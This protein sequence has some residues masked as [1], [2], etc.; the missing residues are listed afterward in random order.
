MRNGLFVILGLCALAVSV[1][2]ATPSPSAKNLMWR[3]TN[4]ERYAG[5]Y[6]PDV[7]SHSLTATQIDSIWGITSDSSAWVSRSNAFLER[8]TF[9]APIVCA[10]TVKGANIVGT[11]TLNI[12]GASTL[13]GAVGITGAVT[14][15]GATGITGATT[16]TGATG[17][18][19]RTTVTG[20]IAGSDSVNGVTGNFSGV[21]KPLSITLPGGATFADPASPGTTVTLT[22]THIALVGRTAVTGVVAGSDSVIGVTGDFSGK[23]TGG[24]GLG[25]TGAG[26]FSGRVTATDVALSDSLLAVTGD[27]SGAVLVGGILSPLSVTLPGG[28]TI[29]N[30]ASPGTTVTVTETNIALAGAVTATTAAIGSSGS[31]LTKVWVTGTGASDSLLFIVGSDTFVATQVRIG[32]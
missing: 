25:I 27:F 3:L 18:T 26:A 7:T 9:A 2:M 24:A 15:T 12:A 30:P 1:S 21:V 22:E 32:H 19:G 13:G 17:I 11:G 6:V 4:V 10:D 28:G 29:A 5:V 20:V 8:C 14:V 31:V 23:I 16:I